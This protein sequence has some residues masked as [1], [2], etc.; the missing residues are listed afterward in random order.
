MNVGTYIYTYLHYLLEKKNF[1]LDKSANT[2]SLQIPIDLTSSDFSPT[3]TYT[4]S[5]FQ[6]KPYRAIIM[7]Q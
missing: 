1:P 3:H 2:I 6:L 4:F 5:R 7:R